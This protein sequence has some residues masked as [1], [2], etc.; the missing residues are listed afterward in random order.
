MDPLYDQFE[1]NAEHS[2]PTPDEERY[3]AIDQGKKLKDFTI[4]TRI[5]IE[6]TILLITVINYYGCNYFSNRFII[7]KSVS[8][9]FLPNYRS[10]HWQGY[11]QTDGN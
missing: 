4:I 8:Y 6:I 7:L 10:M 1:V 5:P 2:Q 11:R 9:L 3:T